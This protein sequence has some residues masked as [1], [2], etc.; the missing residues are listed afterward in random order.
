MNLMEHL[1]T[2]W[3]SPKQE[4]KGWGGQGFFDYGRSE[5]QSFLFSSAVFG[6]KVS[7]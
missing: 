4:H 7:Y 2:V 5:V 6:L 1:A 3:R